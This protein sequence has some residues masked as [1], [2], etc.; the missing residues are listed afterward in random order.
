M[1]SKTKKQLTFF[2]LVK[3]YVDGGPDGLMIMWKELFP[4]R[5]MP[6]EENIKKITNVADKINYADLEDLTSGIEGDETLGNE[7][8]IKVGYWM[9]FE[10]WYKSYQGERKKGEFIAKI[11][12]IVP[13]IKLVNFNSEDIYSKNGGKI[14]PVKRVKITTTDNMWVDFAYFD[15]I[16]ETAKNKNDLIIK[17]EVRKL[18]REVLVESEEAQDT[19]GLKIKKIGSDEQV[20]VTT[21]MFVEKISDLSKGKIKNVGIDDSIPA[22]NNIN[23]EWYQGDLAGTIQ[24]VYP[25]AIVA[26]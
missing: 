19:G 5:N 26:I 3:S 10:S 9:K 12:K 15:Q 20:S 18:V 21:G 24:T 22:K 2:R 14:A 13:G 7:K 11:K 16:K 23:I 1:P 8:E 17:N 6:N 25:D 4:G